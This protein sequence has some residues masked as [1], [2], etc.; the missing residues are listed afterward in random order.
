MKLDSFL[1]RTES[2]IVFVV[3]MVCYTW[4]LTAF[5]NAI[6]RVFHFDITPPPF[7]VAPQTHPFLCAGEILL[8]A[9]LFESLEL[10]GI[11]E[12]ARFFRAPPWLQVFAGAIAIGFLHCLSV[13]GPHSFHWSLR[14]ISIAPGFAIQG[15]AY[16][17]WRQPSWLI[18]FGIVVSIHALH[19]LIPAVPL[20]G[21]GIC[22]LW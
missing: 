3:V 5:L 11:V 9:P 18:A 16:L 2:K 4:T 7:I 6:L 21:Y 14:G 19:N 10:I 12:L 17:Y 22:H 13:D 15:A 1:P 8:L 20:I